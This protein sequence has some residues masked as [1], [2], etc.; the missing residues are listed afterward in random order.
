MP[1]STI[2]QLYHGGQFYW[3]RKP[4]YRYQKKTTDLPQVTDKLYHI[5]LYRVH[6]AWAEFELTTLMV[7]F[8][9]YCDAIYS[10]GDVNRMCILKIF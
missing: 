1:L 10:R 7:T 6:L 5:M 3:W 2:F 8:Q 4:E 9:S